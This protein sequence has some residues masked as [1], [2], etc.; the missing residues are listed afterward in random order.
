MMV[1]AVGWFA[2]VMALAAVARWAAVMLSAAAQVRASTG[3]SDTKRANVLAV[4]Q[5]LFHAGPWSVAIAA[6]VAYHIK[7]E[8]WAPWFFAGFGAS[9]LLMALLSVRLWLRVK[10]RR[11]GA[12]NANAV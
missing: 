6:F 3:Q 7:G 12:S 10:N 5:S 11:H 9:F 1:A 2:G 4:C 8:A